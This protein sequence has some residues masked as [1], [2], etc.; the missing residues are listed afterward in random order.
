MYGLGEPFS[1]ATL[2]I[3]LEEQGGV[4]AH[5]AD[6]RVGTGATK[7][8]GG[9]YAQ[10]SGVMESETFLELI[11][12]KTGQET[13]Q[14]LLLKQEEEGSYEDLDYFGEDEEEE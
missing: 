10:P 11:G 4:M 1:L 8:V 12:E 5:A 14:M 3:M 9:G 7:F 13:L 2:Y 6:Y